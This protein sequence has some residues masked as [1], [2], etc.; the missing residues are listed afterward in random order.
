MMISKVEQ[1]IKLAVTFHEGQTD[2]AGVPYILHPLRVMA[3]ARKLDAAG[4]YRHQVAGVLHDIV[5]DTTLSLAILKDVFGAEI[6]ADVDA[7]THRKDE[8]FTAYLDR[9]RERPV[10]LRVKLLDAKDNYGRLDALVGK[11]KDKELERLRHKYNT[12][13]PQ[14]ESAIER[15][16]G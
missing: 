10:A 11:L 4:E 8:P 2:K 6:A 1:A 14:I 3:E 9:L 13:I 7:L 16:G 12:R 15:C 5:E